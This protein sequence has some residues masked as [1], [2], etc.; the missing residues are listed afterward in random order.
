MIAQWTRVSLVLL[1]LGSACKARAPREEPAEPVATTGSSGSGEPAVVAM[2]PAAL[3]AA[4]VVIAPV[5]QSTLVVRAEMPGTIEAPRDALVIVN[6]RAAGVVDSLALDVGDRVKAGQQLAT[7]RSLDLAA[8]QADYRRLALADQFAAK[9]L[10]RTESMRKAGVVSERRVEVDRLEASQRHLEMQEA[11]GRIRLLGGSVKGTDG[12]TVIS[13][14]ISGAVAS[15]AVNRG[16]AVAV[17][18]PLFTVVDI[19]RVLVELRAPGGTKVE[20]GT[21]VEFKVEAIPD[22]NFTAVVKSASDLLDPVTRRFAIRCSVDNADGVLKPGMFVTAALPQDSVIAITVPE[23]AVQDTADGAVVFVARDGGRFERRS[24]VLGLR[25]DG[26]VA[27]TKGLRAGDSI[28]VQ[29]AF[30]VR[31]QL[32]KSTLEE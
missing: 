9:A 5:T 25:T 8:A 6:T 17:N 1:A 20:P 26:Q 2:T 13:S 31:T 7:I 21:K 22:R 27:V 29:G 24:V 12:T 18:G 4:G 15:R 11:A 19:A 14:P 3:K 32:E 16:E 28:V 30:W 23:G 10:E